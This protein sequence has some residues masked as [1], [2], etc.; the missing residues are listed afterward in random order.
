MATVRIFDK[1]SGDLLEEHESVSNLKEWMRANV[2]NYRDVVRPPYSAQLNGRDWSHVRHDRT[3]LDDDIVSITLEPQDPTTLLIITLLS[4]AYSFYVASN[5]PDFQDGTS[6]GKSIYAPDARGNSIV[7]SGIIREVA[8]SIQVFPDV[9]STYR[10]YIDGKEFLHLLLSVGKGNF[11]LDES[12]LYIANTPL[13]NY[14][15][16]T[17]L[18]IYEPGDSLATDSVSENWYT[19]DEVENLTLEISESETIPA[20]TGWTYDVAATSM[21]A[22]FDTV[23]TQFPFEVDTLF[24]ISTNASPNRSVFLRV[25]SFSGASNETA[26]LTEMQ[27]FGTDYYI[28]GTRV[29]ASSYAEV[30]TPA[31]TTETTQALTLTSLGGSAFGPYN[32]TPSGED[33]RYYEVDILFPS[34]LVTIT[35]K[36]NESDRTAI[37][38]IR[39]RLVGTT[40][41]TT[42]DVVD[43]TFTAATRDQLGYTIEVD[44]GAEGNYEFDFSK[45]INSAYTE[46]SVDTVLI[47]RVKSKLETP[48]SYPGITTLT[49]AIQ[50]DSAFTKSSENRINIRGAARKLPT[51]AELESGSW[52]LSDAVTVT[53]GFFLVVNGQYV[54]SKNFTDVGVYPELTPTTTMSVSFSEN[55]FYM[56][57]HDN[58]AIKFWTL[59][60]AFRPDLGFAYT[61]YI[62]PPTNI[63]AAGVSRYNSFG[64]TFFRLNED[65]SGN[66]RIQEVLLSIAYDGSTAISGVSFT[67]STEIVGTV[68]GWDVSPEGDLIWLA[69]STEQTIHQYSSSIGFNAGTIVYDSVTLDVSSILGD[70]SSDS[71]K[72]LKSI[73]ISQYAFGTDYTRLVLMR[74]DGVLFPCTLTTPG[75]ITTAVYDGSSVAYTLGGAAHHLV[76]L[77]SNYY[78]S[79]VVDNEGSVATYAIPNVST[80]SRASRSAMRFIGL[81]LRDALGDDAEALVD[82]DQMNIVDTSLAARGDFLDIDFSDETTLW[83]AIKVICAAVMCEPTIKEGKFFPKKLEAGLTQEHLYTPDIMLNDGL[84]IDHE[85][86]DSQEPDGIDVEYFS[87]ETNA[88]EVVECRIAGDLGIRPKRMQVLGV[89]T[90]TRTWRIG[91]RERR[92]MA[93]KPATYTFSTEMDALN[94]EYGD[95]IAIASDVFSSQYGEVTAVSG[96]DITLDFEPDFSAGGTHYAAFRD[97]YGAFSGL[98]TV[99]AGPSSNQV[100]LSSPSSLDFTPVTDGSTDP[101]FMSF[102]PASVWGKNAIIRRI[103]P[104]DE[105]SVTVTAEEYLEE[106]YTDDDN[107]PS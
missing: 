57:T 50:G 3:L 38:T 71:S 82:W 70:N 36:G 4:A 2:P 74:R 103:S 64:D 35:D 66:A 75:D 24:K 78:I 76:S 101:S 45:I 54:A 12:N 37:I 28:D 53:D 89:D 58:D 19:S 99:V 14:D 26:A 62:N 11:S 48:T 41:W 16:T 91:M 6:E 51:L 44:T 33:A 5:L 65:G 69:D 63:G 29:L 8:G 10:K 95:I 93:L 102:G 88:M 97:E 47:K 32:A 92:R 98:Y 39:Y 84:Q 46:N 17:N 68:E 18:N 1:V 49:L 61:G 43:T 106:V 94:S 7:P 59:G 30:G 23:A 22:Y 86:Y 52:D 87:S 67:A 77:A 85:F 42:V 96:S 31:L 72:D 104:N 20:G 79:N 9:L 60:D 13:I 80:D 15:T 56:I 55:G 100:T 34:G 105:T 40:S 107:S 83:D 73:S 21:T 25:D 81:M 27:K 90:E